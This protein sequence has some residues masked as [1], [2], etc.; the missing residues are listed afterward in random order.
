MHFCL[1]MRLASTVSEA[2][3][4]LILNYNHTHYTHFGALITSVPRLSESD[5][6]HHSSLCH[7][8]CTTDT[9]SVLESARIRWG[10]SSGVGVTWQHTG[11]SGVQCSLQYAR[12]FVSSCFLVECIMLFGRKPCIDSIDQC[13]VH[14]L[15]ALLAIAAHALS[16]G[17]SAGSGLRRSILKVTRTAPSSNKCIASSNKCP[18]S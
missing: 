8:S 9:V 7:C 4:L 1:L 13:F 12:M 2:S 15:Q 16:A 14:T 18:T 10:S 5:T 17:S 6:G 11:C 3:I